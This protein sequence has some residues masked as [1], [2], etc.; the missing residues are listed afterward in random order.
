MKK[1]T[2]LF[3]VLLVVSVMV[4]SAFSTAS[5]AG[6][7]MLQGLKSFSA[8]VDMRSAKPQSL[9]MQLGLIH[10]MYND[11]SVRK[12]TEKPDFV[13]I[14]IGPS[15]KLVSTDI[16]ICLVAADLLGVDRTSILPEIKHVDNGWISLVGY[17]H[18]G[19]GLVPVY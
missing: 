12:V 16:E 15:V 17:Q 10:A 9:A 5:A 2:S 8:V 3:A 1:N 4:F 18:L 14:F 6:Y 11:A 13:V 19:Y 7:D